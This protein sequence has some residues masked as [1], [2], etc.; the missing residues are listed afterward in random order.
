[1]TVVQLAETADSATS[2][3]EDPDWIVEQ[4]LDGHRVLLVCE[5]AKVTAY[6]RKGDVKS[7]PVRLA[8]AMSE[9]LPNGR[10]VLDGEL[11][12]KQYWV[13]DLLEVSKGSVTDQP[14]SARR[15]L[16]DRFA[17]LWQSSSSD[18]NIKFTNW[19]EGADNKANLYN[20]CLE[21]AKEGVM[22]KQRNAPYRKGRQRTWR[23][24]K[25]VKTC[26]A[27]VTELNRK[28][29]VEAMSLGLFDENGQLREAGGCRILPKFAGKISVGD[30]VEVRYL[31]S[32]PETKKLYQP[33]LLSIRDDK[34][35]KEC[36]QWQLQM[37]D[38]KVIQ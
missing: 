33:V 17:D 25:F 38:K 32:Q 23:K 10:W 14:W 22:F 35:P 1:M 31:Y 5:D 19:Y 37:T 9:R 28:G 20:M 26:E 30:I 16:L 12:G 4:K 27:I 13:F 18:P 36:G 24:Y 8:S 21:N 29:K 6:N 34:D 15:E 3:L 7:F 2:Y 11:M